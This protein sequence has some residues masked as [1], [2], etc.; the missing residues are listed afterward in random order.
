MSDFD[1]KILSVERIRAFILAPKFLFVPNVAL[2]LILFKN[3][4]LKW[5][6]FRYKSPLAQVSRSDIKII[7]PQ[8]PIFDFYSRPLMI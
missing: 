3:A 7:L 2:R 6:Y 8:I 4:P 1:D 5:D